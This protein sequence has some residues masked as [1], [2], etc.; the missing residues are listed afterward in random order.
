[1]VNEETEPSRIRTCRL[2]PSGETA[3]S[4]GPAPVA[5]ATASTSVREP[6]AAMR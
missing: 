4:V 3:A 6:S 1:M 5:A 2:P